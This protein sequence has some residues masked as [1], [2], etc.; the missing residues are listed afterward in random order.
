MSDWDAEFRP[1]R[2]PRMAVAGA[3]LFAL[4]GIVVAI[5]ND[6]AL[7]ANW[8]VVDQVA[9]G[10]LAVILAGAVVYLATRPRLRVGP[11]GLLV[12]NVLEDR[13]IPWPDVVDVVFPPGKR[14]ARVELQAYEYV[15]VL[16]IQSADGDRAV[17]AMDTVRSLMDRY[18]V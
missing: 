6:R 9:I 2:F 18:R 7:G 5:I 3:G 8:R 1:R 15:P 12:R 4:V 14:W 13:L 16:A 17:A 10:S 11:A